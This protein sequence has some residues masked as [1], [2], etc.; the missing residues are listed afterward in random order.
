MSR[1]RSRRQSAAPQRAGWRRQIDSF[2]GPLVLGSVAAAVVGVVALIVIGSRG[3]GVNET[4]YV[5]I[6]RS[7]V[8]GRVEGAADA[9]VRII[10]FSD[11][12]CPFC[13]QFML[14]TAPALRAE[15]VETG[16]ASIEYFHFAFLGEESTRAAEAAECAAEQGRFWDY[17]DL[18]FLRQGAEN[19]GVFSKGNLKRFA[20]ELAGF[21]TAAFDG[22]L[23]AGRY[24]ADVELRAAEARAAG[25]SSTPSF[26]VNGQLVR[27][28]LPIESWREIIEQIRDG[29]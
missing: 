27:G 6:E 15:F 23:D 29:G 4:P 25:I 24:R 7:V 10:E 8:A 18:L 3:G 2:G 19:A 9:P 13:R 17:H 16:I 21:D 22:C 12:Q 28:A 11:F 20:R 5:P 26:V 1:R 14:E